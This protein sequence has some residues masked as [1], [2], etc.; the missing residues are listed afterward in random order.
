MQIAPISEQAQAS[1]Y[2]SDGQAAAF[3]AK[4]LWV[5]RLLAPTQLS[6][7]PASRAALLFDATIG[8]TRLAQPVRMGTGSD[9]FFFLKGS[10]A[11]EHVCFSVVITESL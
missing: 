5:T 9:A 2:R 3:P 7:M 11:T 8:C 4:G 6:T 1:G 10:K